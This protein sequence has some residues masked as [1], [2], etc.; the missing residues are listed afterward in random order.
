MDNWQDAAAE[1]ASV[2][3]KINDARVKLRCSWSSPWF[4]GHTDNRYQLLP[5][6]LRKQSERDIKRVNAL[7]RRPASIKPEIAELKK[8]ITKLREAL[9]SAQERGD[10]GTARN[11]Q[12]E[13]RQHTKILKKKRSNLSAIQSE[14]DQ[15]NLVPTGEREAF[16]E[17]SAR[18]GHQA[19][20]SWE[21]LA[22]MQHYGTPTRLLDWSETLSSGLFF[23]LRQYLVAVEK[24]W[25]EQKIAENSGPLE[26]SPDELLVAVKETQEGSSRNTADLPTPAIWIL[27][28][29]RLSAKATK[30]LR[31]WDLSRQ[32][33]YDYFQNIV[34]K[35]NWD[36]E[37][38]LP[39]FS[40]WR[41]PRIAAQQGTFTV[42]GRD[43]TPL[44]EMFSEE[45]VKAVD[46]PPYAALYGVYV[47]KHVLS[48]DGFT[49]FRDRG[50]LS[51]V[52]SERYIKQG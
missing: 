8:N 48:V 52:I 4:R 38:P 16:I 5:S 15:I 34:V 23:A 42:W 14:I 32:P 12:K 33:E 24:V 46:I 44:N 9:T 31:I 49:L 22:E 17:F 18:A 28:P 13:L 30:R 21:V 40:P 7:N 45:F 6:L 27:N 39:M 47:L 41:N 2:I 19:T 26:C 1:W 50:S 35:K 43:R 51:A 20:N 36:F 37:H 3:D 29:F 25:S 10:L 11:I